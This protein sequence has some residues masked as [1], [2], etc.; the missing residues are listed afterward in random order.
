MGP[1]IELLLDQTSWQL[2][3]LDACLLIQC[4]HRPWPPVRASALSRGGAAVWEPSGEVSCSSLVPWTKHRGD[5]GDQGSNADSSVDLMGAIDY[6][7]P[8]L[9][10]FIPFSSKWG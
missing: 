3:R 5:H 7:T 4:W 1:E 9:R 2:K 8:L 10:T 6:V